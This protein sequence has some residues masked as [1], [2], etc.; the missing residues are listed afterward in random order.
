MMARISH[1]VRQ[2]VGALRPHVG[3]AERADAYCYL[4]AEQQRLFE[5][6]MLRDQQ[7]GIEVYRHVR[8]A[9]AADLALF[10]AALLH[11]SGKGDVRL[12]QRVAYVALGAGAPSLLSRLASERGAG[13]R[14]AFHRLLHH[15]DIGADLAAAAGADA[16]IVRMIREQDA[17]AP[18]GRLA[19]LQAAD[20]A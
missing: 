7:H 16:D 2:F 1:R 18:D 8:A 3:D 17:A 15:P 19:L 4:N 6:M 13:W 20:E 10:T 14:Q 5:S 12:W 9:A 11:D